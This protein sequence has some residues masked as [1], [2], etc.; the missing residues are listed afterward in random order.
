MEATRTLGAAPAGLITVE[1]EERLAREG[2]NEIAAHAGASVLQQLLSTFSNPLLIILL[3]AAAAEA[4]LGERVNAAIV[5]AMVLLSAAIDFF[6]SYRSA[7]AVERLRAQ[8]APTATVLR[9]G[10]WREIPRRELVRGALTPTPTPAVPC[11][12]PRRG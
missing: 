8:V 4:A 7:R 5:V 11:P 10:R 1:A 6:Q 2:P 12:P 9:D 3:V